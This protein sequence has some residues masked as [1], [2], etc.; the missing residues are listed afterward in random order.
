MYTLRKVNALGVCMNISLGDSYTQIQR[1]EA[2]EEFCKT[3][4][5]Y[6]GKDHVADLDDTSDADTKNCLQFIVGKDGAFVVPIMNTQTCF[7]MTES[8]K[9]FERLTFKKVS[10]KS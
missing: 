4:K 5:S 2:Y 7:I 1:F 6:F 10:K 3:F 9:T 8:G